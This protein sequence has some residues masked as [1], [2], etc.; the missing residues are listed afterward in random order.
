MP[1]LGT[2]TLPADP[3]W[4]DEFSSSWSP[5]ARSGEYSLTGAYIVQESVRLAGRPITLDLAWLTRAEVIAVD[6]M[7]A[8]TNQTF[9]LVIAQGAFTVMFR[10]PPYDIKP[11]RE[12]SDPNSAENYTVTLHLIES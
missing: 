5:V 10:D 11:L 4:T 6:A 9:L 12:I 2:L 7:V 3:V 8:L 1:T